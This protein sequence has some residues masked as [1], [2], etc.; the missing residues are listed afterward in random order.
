[1]ALTRGTRPVAGEG[2]RREAWGAREP[3]QKKNEVGRA[4]MNSD[5]FYFYF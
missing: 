2:G 5:Y 1:V 3:I 4:Q